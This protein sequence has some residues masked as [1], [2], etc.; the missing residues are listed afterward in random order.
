MPELMQ[1]I[2]A[3]ARKNR[4]SSIPNLSDE[5]TLVSKLCYRPRHYTI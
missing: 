4:F 1:N 2:V 3:E 5:G